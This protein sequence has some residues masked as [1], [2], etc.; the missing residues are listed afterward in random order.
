MNENEFS[1]HISQPMKTTFIRG[2]TEVEFFYFES[3]RL[4]TNPLLLMLGTRPTD[5]V[6]LILSLR[7]THESFKSS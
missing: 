5:L 1:T 7:S 3:G 4:A 6:R 2:M